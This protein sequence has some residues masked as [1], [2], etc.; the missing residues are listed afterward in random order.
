M[1]CSPPSAS[2]NDAGGQP[3]DSEALT[4]IR[5]SAHTLKGSGRMVGL[6]DMGEAAWALE[7]TFNMWLRQDMAAT[8]GT[9]ELIGDAHQLFSRWV[10]ALESRQRGHSRSL[11]AGC[12]EAERL[13]GEEPRLPP[14]PAAADRNGSHVSV[15]ERRKDIPKP[16]ETEAEA[17]AEAEALILRPKPKP[18]PKQAEFEAEVPPSWLIG[19]VD[20]RTGAVAE[21][22]EEAVV[23]HPVEPSLEAETGGEL[24]VVEEPSERHGIDGGTSPISLERKW[25]LP[26]RRRPSPLRR[27]ST[28]SSVKRLAG[29][30]QTLVACHVDP[31]CRSLCP[32]HST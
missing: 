31:G 12:A 8:S 2:R 3:N 28:T 24:L 25:L 4:T 17:E 10:A 18:K 1:R 20:I 5:R 14:A 6:T 13:R 21:I 7:Q 19:G 30:S 29:T 16:A 22:P 32:P 15:V 23:G 9:N 26:I 27:P 11:G